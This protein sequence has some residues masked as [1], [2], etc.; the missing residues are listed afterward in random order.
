VERRHFA[1]V[2]MHEL[3]DMVDPAIPGIRQ[4]DDAAAPRIERDAGS[5]AAFAVLAQGHGNLNWLSGKRTG[6]GRRGTAVKIA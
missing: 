1:S 5:G 2:G 3:H 4:R 6:P